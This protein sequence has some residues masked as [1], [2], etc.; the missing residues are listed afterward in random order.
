LPTPRQKLHLLVLAPW[1]MTLSSL[2]CP[3]VL[4][5]VENPSKS[6]TSSEETAFTKIAALIASKNYEEADTLVEYA[7]AK[8]TPAVRAYFRVGKAYFDHDEWQRAAY[9]L[10]K[11]LKAQEGNDQAHLLLGVA[12]RELKQ[13]EQAERE[14]M[15]A[16]SLN[17]RSDVNAYFAGQ[18]LLLELKFE[19]A[20]PY[21]YEA[22]KLNPRNALAYRA[23]GTTQV[24]LG[25]YGLAEPYYRKA[26][27]V[28]GNSAGSDP[29]P[30]LDLSFILLLGHDPAK[31]EEGWKLAKRAAEIQPSSGGAHYLEGKALMSQGRIKE[32]LPELVLATR[33]SPEDSKPHFQ[34]VRAYERLGEKD[35]AYAE[36]QAL[37]KTKQRSNQ[38]GI[39]SGSVLPST[40]E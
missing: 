22:V 18:Q 6:D 16:V 12:Y 2:P 37:A 34:L 30:L 35:K 9:Y 17:P 7:I 8:G 36:R 1:F 10:E 15:K 19:A 21:L 33:L 28:A 11:S 38:Q 27:E 3:A 5:H 20:L 29:G 14:F 26:I 31:V 25:N 39:A 4:Q 24:H 13:P 40:Q 23:L 32:A